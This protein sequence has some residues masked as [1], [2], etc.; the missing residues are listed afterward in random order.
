MDA[1]VT[2]KLDPREFDLLRTAIKDSI[3]VHDNLF[4]TKEL[5]ASARHAARAI[6]AQLREL[7]TKLQ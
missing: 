7:L 6:E 2:I 4:H 1:V 3:D 5:D